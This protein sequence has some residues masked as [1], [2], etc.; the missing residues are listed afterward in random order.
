MAG[1]PVQ[2][3]AA[4]GAAADRRRWRAASFAVPGWRTRRAGPHTRR[5]RANAGSCAGFLQRTPERPVFAVRVELARFF[6]ELPR[7]V[8]LALEPQHLADVRG[9]F[10]ILLQRERPPQFDQRLTVAPQAVQ[11]PAVAVD[12]RGVVRFGHARAI[13]QLEGLLVAR[14]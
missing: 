11:H 9:D 2:P 1:P 8:L 3:R 5:W 6:E 4:A 12:D 10:R 13:N 7:L 14:S